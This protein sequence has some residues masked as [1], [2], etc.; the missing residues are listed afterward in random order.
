L[1]GGGTQE[2]STTQPSKF[3]QELVELIIS[4]LIHD[5]RTLLAC[6]MTSYS[7]YIAAVP[8]LHHTLTTDNDP[9]SNGANGKYLWPRPL[10]KS[11]NLGLLP[12]VKQLRIRS[13]ERPFNEFA[14]KKLGWRALAYFS[15][16]TNLQELGIDYLQVSSFMPN[17]RRYFGHLSPTLRFLALKEPEGSCRQI[18]YFIGLFPNLQDLKLHYTVP[19]DELESTADPTLV[20][21]SVPPLRGRL[22]LTCFTR[23]KLVKEM[24]SLFGGLHFCQMDLF[25]VKCVRLLLDACAGTLET[26]RLYPTDACG[27]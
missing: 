15:A 23:E 19:R 5:K 8:H 21:L 22:T 11:Y 10:R 3:P 14:P 12:L 4:H 24:I 1:F 20:P 27:E 16:L 18:L 9:L 2:A 25:G 7:W 13:G 17:I 6:S 26:L